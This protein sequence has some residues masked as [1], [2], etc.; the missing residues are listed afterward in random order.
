VRRH[1]SERRAGL[2]GVADVDIVVDAEGPRKWGRRVDTKA[3]SDAFWLH[4]RFICWSHHITRSSSKKI[5]PASQPEPISILATSRYKQ[6]AD[7]ATFRGH[8]IRLHRS[9]PPGEEVDVVMADASNE[10][11]IRV[12]DTAEH[13]RCFLSG[14]I[15]Y[16]NV[17]G[18]AWSTYRSM[19]RPVSHV[20]L[21]VV[22]EF[23]LLRRAGAGAQSIRSSAL[24]NRTKVSLV[25]SGG[26][27]SGHN[28]C[29]DHTLM[30][31]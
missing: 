13:E 23:R 14:A 19:N 2:G 7:Y 21:F 9:H 27:R 29:L 15:S 20:G 28:Q 26:G 31:K 4:K 17:H 8:L 1:S 10:P 12:C 22:V 30:S 16:S 5:Q 25:R 11:E 6:A 3:G 18:K 24:L